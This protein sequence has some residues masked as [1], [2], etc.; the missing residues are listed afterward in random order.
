MSKATAVA[1][2]NIAFIKYWGK[3]NTRLNLPVN[4]SISMNLSELRTV[5]TVQF[6][7]LKRD[8]VVLDGRQLRGKERVRT[9]THL[10]LIRSVAKIRLR[11]RVESRNNFPVAVG[12]ASSASGF[13]ALTVAACAALKLPLPQK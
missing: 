12:I 1:P 7:Q 8:Q 13:A 2:A 11:A 5:T 10:D 9:V 6:G 4:G 3:R